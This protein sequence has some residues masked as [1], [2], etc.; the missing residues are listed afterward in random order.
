MKQFLFGLKLLDIDLR[1]LRLVRSE[2]EVAQI[3][4]TLDPMGYFFLLR[5]DCADRRRRLS[6]NRVSARRGNRRRDS[7][8]MGFRLS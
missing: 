1:L 7:V 5:G 2:H 8:L 3:A 6:F 4:T